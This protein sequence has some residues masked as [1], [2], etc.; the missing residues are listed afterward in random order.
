MARWARL[1]RFGRY[2]VMGLVVGLA[3][4]RSMIPGTSKPRCRAPAI[5]NNAVPLPD[6]ADGTV[7]VTIARPKAVVLHFLR[8]VL[9]WPRVVTGLHAAER[10]GSNRWRLRFGRLVVTTIET[11]EEPSSGIIRWRSVGTAYQTRGH[12]A[13]HEA[14]DGSCEVV[15]DLRWKPA[16]G[17]IGQP[18]VSLISKNHA[19]R[20]VKRL[21]DVLEAH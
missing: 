6:A 5:L 21:K 1:G 18:F 14:R 8:D 4:T 2:A 12:I 19:R 20:D 11:S 3:A 10:L 7:A 17:S 16:G 15:V 13:V 9:N